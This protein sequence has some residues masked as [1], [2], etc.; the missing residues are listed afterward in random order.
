MSAVNNGGRANFESGQEV[1]LLLADGTIS[2]EVYV[3]ETQRSDRKGHVQV[4]ERNT[5]KSLKVQYRRILPVNVEG[6]SAVI[7]SAGR[8]RSICPKCTYIEMISSNSEHLT[9]PLHGRFD[10]YWLGVKPM[11]TEAQSQPQERRDKKP[12]AEKKRPTAIVRPSKAIIVVDLHK[13][14]ATQHC[15]L[16]TKNVSFDHEKYDVKSHVLLYVNGQPRKYCFNTYNGTLG[17]K[18]SELPIGDF[19]NNTLPIDA[20]TKPWYMVQDLD[21]MREKL[22]KDGYTKHQGG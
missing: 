18:S 14:A 5:T 6:K 22:T 15:E 1:R 16:W 10:L 20:K 11:T 3:I 17:K 13:I 2:N 19:I 8:Y 7:E 9:C 4:K 12:T 21:K